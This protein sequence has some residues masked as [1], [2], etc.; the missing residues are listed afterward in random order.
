M[1]SGK[2]VFVEEWEGRIASW[3]G[4]WSLGRTPRTS[5]IRS[6]PQSPLIPNR[7]TPEAECAILP[8]IDRGA[9]WTVHAD[10]Q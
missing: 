6:M 7:K 2:G 3:R 4:A 5:A 8:G 9:Y 1:E 10:E